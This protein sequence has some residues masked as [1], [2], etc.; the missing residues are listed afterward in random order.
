MMLSY[1]SGPKA[2]PCAIQLMFKW[3]SSVISILSRSRVVIGSPHKACL[4]HLLYVLQKAN[5]PALF[6]KNVAFGL[7]AMAASCRMQS[8][9]HDQCWLF[10]GSDEKYTLECCVWVSHTGSLLP[11]WSGP[12]KGRAAVFQDVSLW[13]QSPHTPQTG[14]YS[15]TWASTH[16]CTILTQPLQPCGREALLNSPHTTSRSAALYYFC[17]LF[18]VLTLLSSFLRSLLLNKKT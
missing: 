5:V 12:C 17:C 13:V 3:S 6:N 9:A 18:T 11:D 4:K 2:Q 14:N 15:F 1:F 10:W 8:G 7:P 16:L